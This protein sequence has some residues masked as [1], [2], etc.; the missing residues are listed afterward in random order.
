MNAL[1][2]A[3]FGDPVDVVT[4]A[5]VPV[6]Q[7]GQGEVRLK[8]VRSPVHNHDLATIR[9]NYGYKPALPAV[10]GSEVLG[11]VDAVGAGVNGVAPGARVSAIVQGG[12]AEYALANAA[13]LVPMPDAI[14]DDTACQL[15]AMPL[16]AVVLFDELHVKAGEWIVQNAAN[17]AVGT[18]LMRIAQS[19][20]VNIINLVR[21]ESAAGELRALGAK[22]VVVTE[23]EHWIVNA[24]DMTGGRPIV[25]A[26]DSI[27]GAQS[28]DMQRLL[29]RFGELIVF[30]GLA[31]AAMKLDPSVMISNELVVRGFWMTAWTQRATPDA[32]VAAARRV[33]ELALK[34][35]LPLPVAGVFPLGDCTTALTA[36]ET[37]GRSGKVLFAP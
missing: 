13:S 26:I 37:P 6:P 12:W 29:G 28:L 18:I 31:G 21:R 15:M 8:I 30:G 11:T 17:G 19:H 23:G 20:G 2:Y 36:A 35:E 9:G 27:T 16:S 5:D 14:D 22:H 24:R 10:G 1:R 3:Q 7:P 32:R 25:R 4:S 33:F 34:G